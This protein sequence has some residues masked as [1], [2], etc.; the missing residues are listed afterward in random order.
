MPVS[1]HLI[2]QPKLN[3][4]LRD[5]KSFQKNKSVLTIKKLK[6]PKAKLLDSRQQ[7]WAL[8]SSGTKTLSVRATKNISPASSCKSTVSVSA[9]TLIG[10]SGV[11]IAC[12]TH[13]NGSTWRVKRFTLFHA[14]RPWKSGIRTTRILQCWP[15]Q[16]LI[17]NKNQQQN[18]LAQLN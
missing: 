7:G 5:F 13:N 18:V 15:I 4:L 11:W 16:M 3:N 9:Q 6:M 10:C 8:L 1:L 2:T 14:L 17:I 12:L